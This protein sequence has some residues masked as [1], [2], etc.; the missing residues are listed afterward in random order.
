MQ[1]RMNMTITHG[2]STHQ[3]GPPQYPKNNMLGA[4]LNL[5]PA[6]TAGSNV[7]PQKVS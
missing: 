6:S 4:T 1:N 5:A 2:Y 7:R 3:H